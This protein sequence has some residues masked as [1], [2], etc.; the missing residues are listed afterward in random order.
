MKMYFQKTDKAVAELASRQR[1]LGL[2]ERA[3][4]LLADGTVL[5]SG[6]PHSRAA[7]AAKRPE[8]LDGLAALRI[9]V[10]CQ[11]SRVEGRVVALAEIPDLA[12]DLARRPR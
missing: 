9:A 11:T 5:E 6:D 12:P 7:F 1:T 10:A 4:L 2:K 8:L 3:L